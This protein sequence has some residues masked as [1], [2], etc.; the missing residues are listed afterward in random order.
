M[1]DGDQMSATPENRVKKIID[2]LLKDYQFI[3]VPGMMHKD[4]WPFAIPDPKYKI[5]WW[6]KPQAGTYGRSGIPDYIGCYSGHLFAIEAKA[7]GNNLTEAQR[8]AIVDIEK[9]GG[10]VFVVRGGPEDAGYL[11]LRNWLDEQAAAFKAR[12][13][14]GIS[15]TQRG[16][17]V[18]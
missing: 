4:T 3:E 15:T 2:N 12:L 16:Q 11:G 5:L 13:I 6:Y 10:T 9:A 14:M 18:V 7:G 8:R 1:G 17:E